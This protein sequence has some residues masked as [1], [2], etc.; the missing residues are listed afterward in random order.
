MIA[1]YFDLQAFTA[2][3]ICLFISFVLYFKVE[4]LKEKILSIGQF[5]FLLSFALSLVYAVLKLSY[6][7]C[8]E[9]LGTILAFIILL[10]LYS[11]LLNIG[12]RLYLRF[13]SK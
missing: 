5:T 6:L 8:I 1:L 12:F 2:F 10:N 7:K 3:I 4:N 9:G 11:V 13:N